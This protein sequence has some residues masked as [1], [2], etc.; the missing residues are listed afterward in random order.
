MVNELEPKDSSWFLV[1][2]L[3]PGLL[4]QGIL[5]NTVAVGHGHE[6]KIMNAE[7]IQDLQNKDTDT[8]DDSDNEYP[9]RGIIAVRIDIN[10][11]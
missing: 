4:E 11:K 5:S 2:G 8:I 3:S 6:L 1:Y 7:L 9:F 10:G